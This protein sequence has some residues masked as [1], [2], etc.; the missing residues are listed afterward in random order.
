MNKTLFVLGAPRSGTTLLVNFLVMN[1]PKICGSSWESQYYTTVYRKPYVLNTFI[2]DPYFKHL[3]NQEEIS[4]IFLK[5]AT[6]AEFFRNAIKFKLKQNNSE[7][8]VEKSPM[9][10]LFYKEILQ[11]FDNPEF[12]LINRNPF[13]NIQSIAFTKWIPMPDFL[14]LRFQSSKTIRYFIATYIYHKYWKVSKVV[15]KHPKCKLTLNYEDIILENINI[16]QELENAIE[17]TLNELFVSR[18]YSDAV[19]HKNRV[20]D[21]TRVDDYKNVMPLSVQRYIKAIFNPEDFFDLII[22]LPII[23]V[24]EI[25]HFLRKLML[26]K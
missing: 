14:P 23:I 19:T 20:L 25:W 22:R 11:D 10:T 7:I 9:H 13:S 26:R 16:K 8:F 2:E 4:K 5:A 21:K 18:P 3:L 24:F 1:Q 6:H 12:I 17:C 15:S